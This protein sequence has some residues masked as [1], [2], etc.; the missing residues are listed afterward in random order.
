M[1]LFLSSGLGAHEEDILA[2]DQMTEEK[3]KSCGK[4]SKGINLALKLCQPYL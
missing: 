1:M 4:L 2:N 3:P